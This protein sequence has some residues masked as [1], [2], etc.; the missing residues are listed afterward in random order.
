[1]QFQSLLLPQEPESKIYQLIDN[2]E[3]LDDSDLIAATETFQQKCS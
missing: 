2:I 3:E 1:M